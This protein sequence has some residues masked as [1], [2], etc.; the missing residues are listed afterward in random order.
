VT[1]G[2]WK[3]RGGEGE[4]ERPDHSLRFLRCDWKN[5]CLARDSPRQ[6]QE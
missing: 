1:L 2:E 6:D 5:A 3:A 4:E